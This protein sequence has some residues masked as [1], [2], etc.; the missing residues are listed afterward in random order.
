MS[1]ISDVFKETYIISN[2]QKTPLKIVFIDLG[3]LQPAT[4]ITPLESTH[5][6]M[7]LGIAPFSGNT[8]FV[9]FAKEKG[10]ERHFKSQ[11]WA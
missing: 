9:K 10:L 2:S 6:S 7:M 8:D 1:N 11:E 3:E 4:D 5:I